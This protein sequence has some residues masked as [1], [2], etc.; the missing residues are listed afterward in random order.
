M[1]IVDNIMPILSTDSLTSVISSTRRSVFGDRA[2]PVAAV[3]AW[4]ATDAS[5][6]D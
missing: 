3:R 6:F 4:N 5:S 1:W 2:F